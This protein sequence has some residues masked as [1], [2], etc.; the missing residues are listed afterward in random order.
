[1]DN[2]IITNEN[3][4]IESDENKERKSD[5]RKDLLQMAKISFEAEFPKKI[6]HEEINRYLRRAS[7]KG[8]STFDIYISYTLIGHFRVEN[9]ILQ[10]SYKYSFP[11][12]FGRFHF[13]QTKFRDKNVKEIL[14]LA[15]SNNDLR[16]TTQEILEDSLVIRSLLSQL[17]KAGYQVELLHKIDIGASIISIVLSDPKC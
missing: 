13:G 14:R 3:L 5:F 1:M 16:P 2:G 4:I 12:V 11:G 6:N 7:E 15:K 17:H 8:D 9:A 10:H